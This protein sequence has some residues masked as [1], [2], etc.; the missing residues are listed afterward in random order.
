MAKTLQT[1]TPLWLAQGNWLNEL[2]ELRKAIVAETTGKPTDVSSTVLMWRLADR[3][4]RLE[5][6]EPKKGEGT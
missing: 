3:A 1:S 4:A 2:R 5:V 6:G